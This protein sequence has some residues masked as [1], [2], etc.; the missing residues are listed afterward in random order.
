MMK[1]TWYFLRTT[2]LEI[3]NND[4]DSLSIFI[5]VTY[6]KPH[7]WLEMLVIIGIISDPL[8]FLYSLVILSDIQCSV[9]K[10]TRST[11]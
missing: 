3:V 1:R 4:G 10:T 9:N 11:A 5:L 6:F 2:R 7:D 8:I